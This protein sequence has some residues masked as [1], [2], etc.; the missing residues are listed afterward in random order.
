MHPL[1]SGFRTSF[2]TLCVFVSLAAC[3]S[4][5]RASPAAAPASAIH[6]LR[7]SWG[8]H[9]QAQSS[10]DRPVRTGAAA[11]RRGC[12]RRNIEGTWISEGYGL[13]LQA[14]DREYALYEV[15]ESSCF[16]DVAGPLDTPCEPEL[17]IDIGEEEDPTFLYVQTDVRGAT[18]TLRDAATTRYDF[19]RARGLPP[20]CRAGGTPAS[21]DPLLNFDLLFEHFDEH[22]AFFRL[23]GVDWSAQYVRLRGEVTP[24]TSPERLFALMTR[25]LAPLQDYHVSLVSEDRRYGR[26]PPA[27]IVE[28]ADAINAF[29]A[30]HY[31]RGPGVVATGNGLLTYR[32]LDDELGYIGIWAM[33]GY[34]NPAAIAAGDDLVASEL[35]GASQAIDEALAALAK[36]RALVVDVRFNGGGMDGVALTI[37]SRFADR[38]R[39]AYRKLVRDGRSF[40]PP[41]PYYV[42]PA[43]ARFDG[44]VA[45]LTSKV[46]LSAAEIF[47]MAMRVLPQVVVLGEA[48]AGAHSDILT[49]TLA[50][51]WEVGLSNEVYVA[52]DGAVYEGRG[53]PPDV[54]VALDAPSFRQ[55]RDAI[56]EAARALLQP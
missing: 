3:E 1:E 22:Y 47:V 7:S 13:A 21:S 19:R 27:D 34:A 43:A 18:L 53:I 56:T 46:T 17:R 11:A 32:K 12:A 28:N 9:P 51:G 33:T 14:T 25:M 35:D 38:K 31:L 40:S 15:S 5:E 6:S 48:T 50:N 37:A 54:T 26:P 30:E 4:S 36:T 16:L 41:R 49:R 8:A 39:L 55:R 52:A 10:P 29:L 44:P 23:R 42:E 45:L 2:S 20:S 24:N